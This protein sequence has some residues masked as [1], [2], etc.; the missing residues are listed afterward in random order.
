MVFSALA[1]PVVDQEHIGAEVIELGPLTEVQRVLEGERVKVKQLTQ[2][3]HIGLARSR[4]I[5]P[6]E[7]VFLEVPAYRALIDLRQARNPKRDTPR[8][9]LRLEH[10][11][12]M[13]WHE[14][15][16]VSPHP[17]PAWL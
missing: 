4:E 15:T 7:A 9:I 10:V 8:Y 11:C 14:T 6:E 13:A 2:P 1:G 5:E 3:F 12:L 17:Y 16:F